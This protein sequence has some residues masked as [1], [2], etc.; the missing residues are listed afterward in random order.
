MSNTKITEKS[1]PKQIID[2]FI[3]SLRGL[4]AF[5]E[6]IISDLTSLAEKNQLISETK[7]D[8]IITP[9]K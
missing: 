8:E 1:I 4:D 7:V 6:K 5:D 9:K 3:D 2:D